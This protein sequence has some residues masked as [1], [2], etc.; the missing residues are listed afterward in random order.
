VSNL[1][2]IISTPD[3]EY[4]LNQ[5][6]AEDANEIGKQPEANVKDIN[7]LQEIALVVDQKFADMIKMKASNE[8]VGNVVEVSGKL[9]QGDAVSNDY[10]GVAIAA[11]GLWKENVVKAE[12]Q[13]TQGNLYG[14]NPLAHW[15]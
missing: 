9:H 15:K 6:R 12:G 2:R 10:H 3:M 13:L 5:M 11:S 8:W 14:F 1:E 7:L 4:R